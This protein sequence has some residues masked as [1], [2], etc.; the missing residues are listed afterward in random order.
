MKFSRVLWFFLVVLTLVLFEETVV[1]AQE[2]L[3]NVDLQ[4]YQKLIEKNRKVPVSITVIDSSGKALKNAYLE[5]NQLSHEFL[6]GNAPE[7]L[8]F[9][10]APSFYR[11]GSRFGIRP[12]SENDLEIY[13]KY[14]IE[15]FNCATVPAFY[16]ADYEPAEGFLP[17]IDA[18]KKIIQWLNDNNIVVK[19]HTLVWGNAPGVGV[20]GWVRAKGANGEWKEVEEL[21]HKRIVR[22]VNEFKNE[23]HMW[24]VVNEPIVQRWFDNLGKNYI[25]ESYKLAKQIDPNAKL[26]LNEFGLLTNNDTRQ[27][28]IT[29]ARKLI[30]EKVSVDIIGIEAHIFNANDIKN[31][32]T[33]LDKIYSALDEI[34]KLGKPIHITE[35]QIPLSAVIEAFNV[36]V[37]TAEQLQAEIAKVFYT[38]FFSH[39][40]VEAIVYWNFYRA[41]QVGSGFLRDDFTLKP[42]YYVLK[43]LIHKEWKTSISAQTDTNGTV[44]F[45]GFPGLYRIDI[46]YAYQEMTL[47]INVSKNKSNDFVI[48]LD[49]SDQE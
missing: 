2:I 20:P 28:F 3:L 34:A 37:N 14:Y 49:K 16:W 21:L 27:K 43:D 30:D 45:M 36:D 18:T 1:N 23:I 12:I 22:E 13:K 33:N 32:L 4:M 19:G 42:I 8:I 31:Q 17:L 11:R 39:P 48:V 7:Y 15:L 35:F 47:D 44:I 24:D 9:A 46:K 10:Y 25:A 40:A 41:W 38:V 6:F 29:L 5:C 26:V